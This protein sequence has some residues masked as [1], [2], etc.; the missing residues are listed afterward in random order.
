MGHSG[1]TPLDA[2]S[3]VGQF[4]GVHKVPLKQHRRIFEAAL[5][6]LC[7][8]ASE[9]LE[10]LL[11]LLL[12]GPEKDLKVVWAMVRLEVLEKELLK[13]AFQEELL[14][15]VLQKELFQRAW[16]NCKGCTYVGTFGGSLQNTLG[17]TG[18][19]LTPLEAA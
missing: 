17:A 6:E 14:R 19:S 4:S 18:T 13:R 8:G 10:T 2:S 16:E 7:P 11:M 3:A 9:Q 15:S 5:I 1:G 12:C